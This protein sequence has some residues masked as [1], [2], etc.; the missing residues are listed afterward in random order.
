[1]LSGSL[2]DVRIFCIRS[3]FI[4]GADVVALTQSEQIVGGMPTTLRSQDDVMDMRS[5]RAN[6]VK[7]ETHRMSHAP[8]IA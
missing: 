1:M 6:D 2:D 7:G 4:M 8:T 3:S 5:P